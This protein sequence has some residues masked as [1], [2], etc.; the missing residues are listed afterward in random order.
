MDYRNQADLPRGIRNNNPG[1]IKMGDSWQGSAGD[2]GTFIIF[3]DMSWG[4]RALATALTNMQK[5]GVNT[6]QDIISTW[7]PASENNTNAYVN[8]V[9]KDMGIPP[10]E[11]LSMDQDTLAS[12]MRAIINHENGAVNSST[13]VSDQDLYA[14]IGM[15][16][17]GLLSLFSATAVAAQENPGSAAALFIGGTILLL[18]LARK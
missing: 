15:M 6:I 10:S 9:S 18:L 8:A 4:T 16:N 12:L 14:G 1:N 2:D 7:A 17:Q 3:A 5:R 11:V 13:Y